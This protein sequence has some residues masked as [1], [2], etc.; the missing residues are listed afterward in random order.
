MHTRLLELFVCFLRNEWWHVSGGSGC[1]GAALG[2]CSEVG[3]GSH[4]SSLFDDDSPQVVSVAA[5]G[6]SVLLSGTDIALQA[7]LSSSDFTGQ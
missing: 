1:A 4:Y 5:Q 6:G 2:A 7:L 3:Q